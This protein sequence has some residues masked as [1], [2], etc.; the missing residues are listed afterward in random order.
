MYNVSTDGTSTNEPEISTGHHTLDKGKQL[1]LSLLFSLVCKHKRVRLLCS[2][3]Y[4]V[5]DKIQMLSQNSSNYF[6]T[7]E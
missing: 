5:Q 3:V 6:F 1:S 4:L 7:K 2:F